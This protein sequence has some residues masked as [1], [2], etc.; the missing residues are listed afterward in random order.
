[1]KETGL[2]EKFCIKY[3]TI[4]DADKVHNETTQIIISAPVAQ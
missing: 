3:Q 2:M 1:M 4:F